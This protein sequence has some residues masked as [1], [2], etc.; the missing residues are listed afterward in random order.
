MSIFKELT[1]YGYIYVPFD[2]T[3]I[4]SNPMRS[5]VTLLDTIPNSNISLNTIIQEYHNMDALPIDTSLEKYWIWLNSIRI[6][7][8]KGRPIISI[9]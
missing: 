1:E 7:N 4:T 6:M 3:D 5:C 9:R 8:W 2:E